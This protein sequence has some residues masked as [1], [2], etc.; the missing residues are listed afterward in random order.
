M[1]YGGVQSVHVLQWDKVLGTF[2]GQGWGWPLTWAGTR[3]LTC[4]TCL[5]SAVDTDPMGEPSTGGSRDPPEV[6]RQQGPDTG[7]WSPWGRGQPG[8][9]EHRS[10][11]WAMGPRHLAPQTETNGVCDGKAKAS[12]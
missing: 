4:V 6:V 11:A 5:L 10:P 7:L 3:V 1:R 2:S 8:P 9:L 12:L